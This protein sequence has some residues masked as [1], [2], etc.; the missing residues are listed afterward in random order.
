METIDKEVKQ[1]FKTWLI[2]SQYL[3]EDKSNFKRKI[4]SN[5]EKLNKWVKPLGLEIT[6]TKTI[7]P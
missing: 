4:A 3:G 7:K 5:M 6:I 2:F 1:Q